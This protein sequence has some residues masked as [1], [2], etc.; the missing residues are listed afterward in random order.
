[1]KS[2]VNWLRGLWVARKYKHHTFTKVNSQYRNGV[3]YVRLDLQ[4]Y[5][6]GT[7]TSV[8]ASGSELEPTIEEAFKRL[9]RYLV[10]LNDRHKRV[11][12][13]QAYWGERDGNK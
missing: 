7:H 10:E 13:S 2:F 1:M 5:G 4:M 3:W 12:Q 11:V 8:W 9:A 6:D